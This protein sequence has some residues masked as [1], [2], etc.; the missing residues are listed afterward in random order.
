M[1]MVVSGGHRQ[2]VPLFG[3]GSLTNGRWRLLAGALQWHFAAMGCGAHELPYEPDRS[4]HLRRKN[5]ALRR[6]QFSEISA[7][8]AG[9]TPLM[10]NSQ[11][12]R[13][14]REPSWVIVIITVIVLSGL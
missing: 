11:V 1:I 14:S 5:A 12:Q 7:A 4:C 13:S 10:T 6:R 3:S 2:R 9:T 8:R